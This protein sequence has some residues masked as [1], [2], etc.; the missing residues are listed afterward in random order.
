MERRVTKTVAGAFN[1]S[2]VGQRPLQKRGA[3]ENPIVK[4]KINFFGMTKT[5][6]LFLSSFLLLAS[7]DKIEEIS[8]T[9]K[10]EY[11]VFTNPNDPLILQVK[12]NNGN[13]IMMVSGNRDENGNIIE[14]TNIKFT[15]G[16]EF[17]D[18]D[19]VAGKMT[20]LLDNEN[21]VIFAN[22][23]ETENICDL[24]FIPQNSDTIY[25]FQISFS[26]E[27]VAKSHSL[28]K[29]LSNSQSNSYYLRYKIKL[30]YVPEAPYARFST[31]YY[32]HNVKAADGSLNF[33]YQ[34]DLIEIGS[35]YAIYQLPLKAWLENESTDLGAIIGYIFD[36]LDLQKITLGELLSMLADAAF[37]HYD[38]KP[39]I[40]NDAMSEGMQKLIDYFL[41]FEL[42]PYDVV[43]ALHTNRKVG[44]DYIFYLNVTA[45]GR[46]WQFKQD[47]ISYTNLV[48]QQ[49]KNYHLEVTLRN[50]FPFE[51]TFMYS[52]DTYQ[53]GDYYSKNG[54]SGIVYKVTEDGKHGMLISLEETS[55]DWVTAPGWCSS[56]G[57]S[58]YLP[59]VADLHEIYAGLHTIWD[60]VN[61][62]IETNGG[63]PITVGTWACDYGSSTVDS[64]TAG[65]S[66]STTWSTI[67]FGNDYIS[68]IC[69]DWVPRI[70]AVRAF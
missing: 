54:V 55:A 37:M 38:V 1:S 14:I 42:D 43:N 6:V 20:K 53:V 64:R 13:T 39:Y 22:Y 36:F 66:T 56:L 26:N 70:R 52:K 60:E 10:S 12:K 18:V 47:A 46:N 48:Q 41:D 45:T 28:F 57:A 23:N 58:W 33:I 67:W 19:Y 31:N 32:T 7:C 34:G 69:F 59:T 25:H 62:N 11:E 40:W 65:C 4:S 68:Y 17:Y 24:D 49:D 61:D 50:I 30:E 21:N 35:N 29:S 16:S 27:Q 8:N 15:K 3:S 2:A 5:L 44:A 9:Q 51:E 63:I